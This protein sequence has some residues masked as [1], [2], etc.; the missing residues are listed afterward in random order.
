MTVGAVTVL[1][2]SVETYFGGT[3]GGGIDVRSALHFDASHV[4]AVVREGVSNAL[5]H[6][7]AD[8]IEVRVAA[9]PRAGE[10]IVEISDDGRGIDPGSRRS[11]LENLRMRATE[12]EGDFA[13]EPGIN[14]RGTRLRWQVPLVVQK[15]D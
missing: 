6:S 10:L 1:G 12:W 7:G 13:V 5:R 2:S 4:D 3:A 14:G 11:G 15:A 8:R 9:E